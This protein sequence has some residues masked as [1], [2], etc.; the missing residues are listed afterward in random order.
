MLRGGH[1]DNEWSESMALLEDLREILVCLKVMCIRIYGDP[2]VKSGLLGA[3]GEERVVLVNTL[4]Q[5][6]ISRF[7]TLWQAQGSCYDPLTET[8]LKLYVEY[9]SAIIEEDG[10]ETAVQ[11]ALAEVEAQWLRNRWHGHHAEMPEPGP[12]DV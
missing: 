2:A 3:L 7:R 11:E 10:V 5:K 12:E 9:D 6:L 8:F 4:D 1:G